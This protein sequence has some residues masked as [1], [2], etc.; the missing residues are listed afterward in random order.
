[1]NLMSGL[2]H[3]FV[4]GLVVLISGAFF[5]ALEWADKGKGRRGLWPRD[6]GEALKEGFSLGPIDFVSAGI[7]RPMVWL[8]LLGTLVGGVGITVVLLSRGHL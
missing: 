3:M 1:M 2:A 4:P 5:V 6:Y 7:G 8:G